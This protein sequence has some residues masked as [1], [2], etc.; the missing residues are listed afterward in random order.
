MSQFKA[1]L[2]CSITMAM[3]HSQPSLTNFLDISDPLLG[4]PYQFDPLGDPVE[5]N[6][7]QPGHP[8][9]R[10]TTPNATTDCV[11]FVDDV[12]S[13]LYALTADPENSDNSLSKR[14]N[15]I[16]RIRLSLRY[17]KSPYSWFHRNHFTETDWLTASNRYLEP[18][19]PHDSTLTITQD[20]H[21]N[22]WWENH[23]QKAK[24]Y[25]LSAEQEQAFQENILAEYP[26][27]VTLRY[28]PW[29][30]I[31][32]HQGNILPTFKPCHP[33]R[34]AVV[35][36]V[37]KNWPTSLDAPTPILISH[38]GFLWDNNGVL[39]LRHASVKHGVVDVPLETYLSDKT[40]HP[41]WIGLSILQPK[42]MAGTPSPTSSEPR[43]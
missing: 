27:Q 37:R 26:S 24:A 10:P 6:L 2:L 42:T 12:I 3:L 32:D 35:L 34:W 17:K 38:L 21:Q 25:A 31:I 40:S 9:S 16:E 5:G 1:Y 41:S 33:H 20:H 29:N 19:A 22:K 13:Q 23:Y 4:T 8:S 28:W 43:L 15:N 7:S 36:F 30:N 18:Y 14:R 11:V 39:T